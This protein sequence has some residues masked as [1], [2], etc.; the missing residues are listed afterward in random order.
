M[1]TPRSSPRGSPTPNDDGSV[2]PQHHSGR[3]DSIGVG[4]GVDGSDPRVQ[5]QD[6]SQYQ[7]GA[8]SGGG[9]GSGGGSGADALDEHTAVRNGDYITLFAES[10]LFSG[11][12]IE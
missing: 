1:N 11:M 10:P 2:V 7:A 4:F 6:D 5:S 9:G 8:G 3:R 12:P